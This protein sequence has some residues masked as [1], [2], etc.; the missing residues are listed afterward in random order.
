[1]SRQKV[2]QTLAIGGILFML[3]MYAIPAPEPISR[4]LAKLGLVG[5]VVAFG[6]GIFYVVDYFRGKVRDPD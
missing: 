3:L 4:V 5:W 2:A 6:A 1:M